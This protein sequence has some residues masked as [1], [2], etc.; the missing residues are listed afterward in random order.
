MVQSDCQS[1]DLSL[2]CEN[3]KCEINGTS[4][5][6]DNSPSSGIS[7]SKTNL[8]DIGTQISISSFK[9]DNPSDDINYKPLRTVSTLTSDSNNKNS[10]SSYE[11][12]MR[13][14]STQCEY[15]GKLVEMSLT[16]T[17]SFNIHFS[18]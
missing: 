6:G 12:S 15:F 4:T 10:L 17:I 16:L 3:Q 9:D 14:E 13:D 2:I 5:C 7:S 8:R 18:W 11:S 1:K